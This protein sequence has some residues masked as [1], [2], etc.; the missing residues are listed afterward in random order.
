MNAKV[1]DIADFM[2]MEDEDRNKY[3]SIFDQIQVQTI[4][5][6]CN[7][8]PSIE[9]KNTK[10]DPNVNSGDVFQIQVELERTGEDYSDFVISPHYPKVVIPK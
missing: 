5:K 4:A 6:A 7:R 8:F 2:N 9:I 3:L 1:D 10:S